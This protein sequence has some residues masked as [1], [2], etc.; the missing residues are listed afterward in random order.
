MRNNLFFNLS[1]FTA[2]IEQA[3]TE[4]VTKTLKKM[5]GWPVLEGEKWVGDEW[6]WTT[7]VYD[8]R[9]EGFS[10]DYLIDFAVATDSKNNSVRV[11][12]V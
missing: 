9:R 1:C 4:R 2:H 6:T 12:E 7:A 10:V 11:I 3:G 5:G 8:F